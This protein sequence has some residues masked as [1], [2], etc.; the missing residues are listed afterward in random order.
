MPFQY[1]TARKIATTKRDQL[2]VVGVQAEIEDHLNNQIVHNRTER[3]AEQTQRKVAENTAEQHLT[4][5]DSGKA[6]NDSA[7]AGVDIR[8]A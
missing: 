5:D 8:E 3:Y 4:D 6:D 7:T 1:G 2:Q